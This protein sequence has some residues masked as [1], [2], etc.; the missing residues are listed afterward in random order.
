MARTWKF[1][2]IMSSGYIVIPA[3]GTAN[4]PEGW[5]THTARAL[6]E[7]YAY[8]GIR[9]CYLGSVGTINIMVASTATDIGYLSFDAS[10]GKITN[11][12]SATVTILQMYTITV[13]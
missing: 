1:T 4:I 12:S 5:P 11:R 7:G 9:F 2:T 10:A 13:N 3:G 6:V 8:G